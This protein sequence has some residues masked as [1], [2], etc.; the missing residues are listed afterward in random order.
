MANISRE[1]AFLM[2]G[3]WFSEQSDLF[4]KTNL[5]SSRKKQMT[6]RV[7]DLTKEEEVCLRLETGALVAFTIPPGAEFGYGE[8]QEFPDLLEKGVAVLI[9]MVLSKDGRDK[10][11]VTFV[12]LS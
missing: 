12:E 2:F 10:E 3:K 8:S 6:C 11:T 1:E 5:P 7:A 9:V 4:C